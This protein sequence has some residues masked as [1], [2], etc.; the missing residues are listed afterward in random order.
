MRLNLSDL[1][2]SHSNQIDFVNNINWGILANFYLNKMIRRLQIIAAMLGFFIMIANAQN[3]PKQFHFSNDGHRL[4]RGGVE[5]T[6]LYDE[7]TIDTIFLSF[8]QLNFW[9]LMLT[10]YQ[11]KTDLPATLV[12]KG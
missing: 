1:I 4:I 12:Y 8:S 7:T 10:N 3:L 11:S 9:N 5:S 6:G 2:I